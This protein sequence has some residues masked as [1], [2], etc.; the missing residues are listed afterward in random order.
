M[1][2]VHLLVDGYRQIACGN[3]DG[4]PIGDSDTTTVA[5]VTC[6]TC[7]HRSFQRYEALTEAISVRLVELG[8]TAL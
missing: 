4:A 7:L 6:V 8:E 3:G 5:K 2:V 1:S